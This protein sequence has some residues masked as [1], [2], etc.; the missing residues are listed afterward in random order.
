V[1]DGFLEF[2]YTENR[3]MVFGIFNNDGRGKF[4]GRTLTLVRAAI[5]LA[6]PFAFRI[7]RRRSFLFL[8][9]LP[10][11]LAG[12]LGNVIDGIRSGFVIDFI[13]I[14]ARNV[15]DWPFLFN[16]ADALLCLGMGFLL[17]NE[18]SGRTAA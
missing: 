2:R 15:L 14:H 11:I 7:F 10:L 3:G 12:A 8:F 9:P 6:L 16:T 4:G 13:H 17:L 1:I 5:A 18:F